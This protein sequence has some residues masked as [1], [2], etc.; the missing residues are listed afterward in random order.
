VELRAAETQLHNTI[1][2]RVHEPTLTAQ[3]GLAHPDKSRRF[4]RRIGRRQI[5]MLPG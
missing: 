3:R 4:A 1:R 5:N 2:A